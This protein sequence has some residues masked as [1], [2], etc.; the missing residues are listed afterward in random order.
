VSAIAESIFKGWDMASAI[1]DSIFKGWDIKKAAADGTAATRAY[2]TIA[3]EASAKLS[4]P[5]KIRWFTPPP[6]NCWKPLRKRVSARQRTCC[7]GAVCEGM[8]TFGLLVFLFL[9]NIN[10][11]LIYGTLMTQIKTG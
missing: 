5:L 7:K 3:F 6:A 11:Y 9:P 2:K 4:N 1:A 8:R 10:I